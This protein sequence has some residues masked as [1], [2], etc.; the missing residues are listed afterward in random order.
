MRKEIFCRVSNKRKGV[1]KKKYFLIG[2][3][4][5]LILQLPANCAAV[6]NW[7][8]LN[9]QVGAGDSSIT[10]SN[11]I[12]AASSDTTISNT[13]HDTAIT[14]AANQ[15]ISGPG[16]SQSVFNTSDKLA[17]TG[18]SGAYITN[19][20]SSAAT[21][22]N[23]GDLYLDGP[24]T[25]TGG[26]SQSS[27]ATVIES[28]TVTINGNSTNFS[29]GN[30]NVANTGGGAT[31]YLT[32]GT[33]YING[34]DVRVLD[35]TLD[36]SSSGGSSTANS[37]EVEAGDLILR[38]TNLTVSGTT[39][40][41]TTSGPNTVTIISDSSG[42]SSNLTMNAGNIGA[43]FAT[44][45]NIGS[46]SSTGNSFTLTGGG[47]NNKTTVNLFDNNNLNI[48][49]SGLVDLISSSTWS[50]AINNSGG[51]LNIFG[52]TSNGILTQSSGTTTLRDGTALNLPTGSS[53]TG[54]NLNIG[55]G[56][57][58]AADSV[59]ADASMITSGANV[60]LTGLDSANKAR[61]NLNYSSTSSGT[62]F[63]QNINMLGNG[64]VN[65]NIA[66]GLTV[67]NTSLSNLTTLLTGNTLIKSGAGTFNLNSTGGATVGSY[68]L[69]VSQGLFNVTDPTS[70]TFS[71][72]TT[73]SGTLQTNSPSTSFNS[74][75]TLTGGA[76]N[77]LNQGFSVTNGLNLTSGTINTMNNVIAT[78]T[79]DSFNF[80][81][82]SNTAN[83]NIDINGSAGTS[84]AFNIGAITNAGTFNISN[85]RLLTE[86]TSSTSTYNVFTGTT[87]GT[88]TS[89]ASQFTMPVRTYSLS[90]LGSGTYQLAA[91]GYNP[92]VFRGQVA[93]V[94]AFANQLT[95]NNILFD[96]I[97]LV[98]PQYLAY[99][100]PNVYAS[101]NPLFSPYQYSKKDGGLWY[102]AYSNIERLTLNEG[103]NTQNNLWGSLVGADFPLVKLR[104]GWSVLPTAYIGY[105]GGYQTYSGVNMYQNGGQ[106][107]LMGS[108]YKGNFIESLLVNVGGYGNNMS[109]QGTTDTT[110]NWFA[111]VASKSA[112]NIG[113]KR[114]LILQPT[115]LV[116]YNAFGP[117]DW[118]T[119][120][121][122]MAMRSNML[123][124]L[125]LAPGLNLIVNKETW[126]FYLK[127]QLNFILMNGSS[128]TAGEFSLPP[129]AMGTTYFQY[130]FGITKR[131]KERLSAYGQIMF[132]NGVRTGIGFQGGLQWK[133]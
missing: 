59:T 125:I 53:I 47:I 110:G 41:G 2:L 16:G 34:A 70:V 72:A 121:G 24:L 62:T 40:V 57:T 87:G 5:I 3:F 9:T 31:L 7:S 130:G 99:E 1:M 97:E 4:L 113:L 71:G 44:T 116:S 22:I 76:L 15:Y 6:S 8:E 21:I 101:T 51:T 82:S 13:A 84:D 64:E 117:Q 118:S 126:S 85:F 77:I 73:V 86:P 23:T 107:G 98:T 131:I 132:S 111:G 30:L 10:L 102:K 104:H 58:T 25:I 91:L 122:D 12:T 60:R 52:V 35:A 19:N 92:Q 115:M 112:Y 65:L 17:I 45:L 43:Y 80:N 89:T 42:N 66:S 127:T 93:T 54:G 38:G 124:G 29:G 133:F 18:A 50:G 83:F 79:I 49:G 90:S 36:I 37:L 88:Y 74:G 14:L 20:G 129:V 103:I 46:A 26:I 128:G 78:S 95:T 56:S 28:G 106:G 32:G 109:L 67:T 114:D 120:Y 48:S 69:D 68:A 75:L 63:D 11:D 39:T 33:N 81:S 94:A 96:H 61:L 55:T 27:G 119:S 108:F 105:V 100:C 123:N